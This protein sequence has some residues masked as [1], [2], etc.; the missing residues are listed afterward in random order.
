MAFVVYELGEPHPWPEA[1]LRDPRK[2]EPAQSPGRLGKSPGRQPQPARLRP[3]APALWRLA[4]R[5]YGRG[6]RQLSQREPA[7]TADQI[8]SAPVITL[9]QGATLDEAWEL[10]RK[11]RFRHVPVLSD[12]GKLMGII[13]DRELLQAAARIGTAGAE[14][15]AETVGELI[16]ARVLTAHPDTPI[17]EIARILFEERIGA[18]PIVGED[19]TLVGIITR[20]DILRALINHAPIELWV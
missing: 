14:R 20:S 9:A 8:M 18:M 12:E 6:Q 3:R 16:E 5:A 7:L 2:T 10:I 11:R 13:S 1:G 4:Q 15:A 17:R 19:G